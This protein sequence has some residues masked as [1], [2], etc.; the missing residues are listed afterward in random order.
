VS[1]FGVCVCVYVC[2]RVC[3]C[4][5]ACVRACVCVCVYVCVCRS[6]GVPKLVHQFFTFFSTF[7]CDLRQK[8]MQWEGSRFLPCTHTPFLIPYAHIYQVYLVHTHISVLLPGPPPG[9][10]TCFSYF[11]TCSHTYMQVCHYGPRVSHSL[12]L[13]L[14]PFQ[15]HLPHPLPHNV[16]PVIL[17]FTH[18]HTHTHTHKT[19]TQNTNTPS[20]PLLWTPRP[21]SL[22]RLTPWRCH[23]LQPPPAGRRLSLA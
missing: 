10:H 12:K 4:V 21:W 6:C 14:L 9:T 5:R 17:M 2:V 1:W 22:S 15:G 16:F 13:L 7:L 23:C 19:H 20:G 18:T 8:V 11:S 3:A